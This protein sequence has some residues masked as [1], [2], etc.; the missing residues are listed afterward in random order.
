[1]IAYGFVVLWYLKH[2]NPDE[3]VRRARQLAPWYTQKWAVSFRDMLEA[4]RRQMEIERLWQTP[5]KGGFGEKEGPSA[6]DSGRNA[7]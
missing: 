1:M 2:G 3:D 6:P 4:F 7:A 5:E